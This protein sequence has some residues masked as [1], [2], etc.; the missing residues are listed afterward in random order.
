MIGTAL[1]LAAL[2]PAAVAA[3]VT[4]AALGLLCRAPQGSEIEQLAAE[5]DVLRGERD[6]AR[7]QLAD[8]QTLAHEAKLEFSAA[9]ETCEQLR[10][11]LATARAERLEA[12]QWRGVAASEQREAAELRAQLGELR[13][14]VREFKA[15]EDTFFEAEGNVAILG[16]DNAM[17]AAKAAIF[18]AVEAPRG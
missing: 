16:A 14:L 4:R 1:H 3:R 15:A 8:A 13:R 5:C 7:A 6:F 2:V 18:A 17:D 10:G 9:R 11:E 12:L